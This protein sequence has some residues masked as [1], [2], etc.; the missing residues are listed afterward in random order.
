M[1][2]M[3]MDG[4]SSSTVRLALRMGSELQRAGTEARQ[5]DARRDDEDAGH[6]EEQGRQR[7]DQNNLIHRFKQFMALENTQNK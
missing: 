5:H 6:R 1:N 4:D 3:G 7:G 2:S